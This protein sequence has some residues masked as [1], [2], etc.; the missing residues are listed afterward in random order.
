MAASSKR[1]E[2]IASEQVEQLRTT[3]GWSLEKLA[4]A[5]SINIRTLRRKL[6][7]EPAYWSTIARIAEALGCP[8]K[9]S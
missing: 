2:V 5:A 1:A 6:A 4:A 3:K 7:G 9:N 8:P